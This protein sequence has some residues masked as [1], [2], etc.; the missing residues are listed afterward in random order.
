MA[1]HNE[2]THLDERL[3][4]PTHADEG[5]TGPDHCARHENHDELLSHLQALQDW[6]DKTLQLEQAAQEHED[7]ITWESIIKENL[8][9]NHGK[10]DQ[11]YPNLALF[12]NRIVLESAD[13][14]GSAAGHIVCHWERVAGRAPEGVA[15]Y[16]AARAAECP[17]PYKI[18][19]TA[20]VFCTFMV[21]FVAT[22]S[23]STLG[24]YQSRAKVSIFL[25]GLA[26]LFYNL[27]LPGGVGS[28]FE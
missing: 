7:P 18:G 11:D 1:L 8:R 23:S 9:E 20:G 22:L 4:E 27:F 3:T 16:V 26:Y 13:E 5:T 12:S 15:A 10:L 17:M 24:R 28:L 14:A 25:C 19:F 21:W 2:T 6:I